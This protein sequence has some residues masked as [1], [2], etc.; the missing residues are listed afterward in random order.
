MRLTS[1]FFVFWL[2]KNEY[3]MFLKSAKMRRVERIDENLESHNKMNTAGSSSLLKSLV[4][5]NMSLHDSTP[6]LLRYSPVRGKALSGFFFMPIR[7]VDAKLDKCLFWF[8]NVKKWPKSLSTG[9]ITNT[10]HSN[11][12]C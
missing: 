1:N 2:I 9:T 4:Y 11:F 12:P 8:I 3:L 7:N 10:R 6:S 5:T